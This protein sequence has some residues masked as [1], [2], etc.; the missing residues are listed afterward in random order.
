MPFECLC[1]GLRQAALVSTAFY[2]AA[3]APSG[4]KVTMYRLLKTADGGDPPSISELAHR[5]SLDRSTLGRNARVLVRDGLIVLA[6]SADA[7]ERHVVLTPK[8]RKALKIAVPLWR[9]AQRDLDRKLD[10]RGTE[11]LAL[12]EALE[13]TADTS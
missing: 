3:L 5:M 11:L 12:L 8:G 6:A 4:L 13:P 9:K 2:D 1:T 7:R 10:G